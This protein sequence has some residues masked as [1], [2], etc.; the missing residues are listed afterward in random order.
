[1][2]NELYC[3]PGMGGFSILKISMQYL[4]YPVAFGKSILANLAGLEHRDLLLDTIFL[5][6]V[7]CPLKSHM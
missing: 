1:M 7:C 2:V 3:S 6:S 4:F 5:L